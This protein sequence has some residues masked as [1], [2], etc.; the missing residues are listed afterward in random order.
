[1]NIVSIDS[2][3][4]EDTVILNTRC[5]VHQKR[6]S[7][8]MQNESVAYTKG[9]WLLYTV[10]RKINSC[11]AWSA[12]TQGDKVTHGL[13]CGREAMIGLGQTGQ[14]LDTTTLPT[15]NLMSPVIVLL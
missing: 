7:T 12:N 8:E 10:M 14:P 13:A 11:M 6:Q 15:A 5:G 1:M 4:G 9:N 2:H 3:G